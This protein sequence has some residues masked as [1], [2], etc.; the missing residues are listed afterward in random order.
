MVAE[1]RGSLQ[2]LGHDLNPTNILVAFAA[3]TFDSPILA[4]PDVHL[5]D[6]AS[7]DIFL[8]GNVDRVHRL[9]A[10]LEAVG[11]YL[12]QHPLSSYALQLGD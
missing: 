11:K 10:V 12:D 6:G 3:P 4:I 5:C 9:E 7:G 2:A 8:Q 1:L